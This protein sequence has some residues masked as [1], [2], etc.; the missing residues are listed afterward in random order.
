KRLRSVGVLLSFPPMGGTGRSAMADQPPC[1]LC[2]PSVLLLAKQLE[3]SVRPTDT[4]VTER[5]GGC[6]E[7]VAPNVGAAG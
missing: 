2:L 4:A 5:W 1:M 3:H 6:P 7:R